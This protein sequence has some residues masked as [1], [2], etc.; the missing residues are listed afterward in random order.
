MTTKEKL[1]AIRDL[2]IK[3]DRSNYD[4]HCW[5]KCALLE[6]RQLKIEHPFDL[7]EDDVMNAGDTTRWHYIFGFKNLVGTNSLV[8]AG[9]KLNLPTDRTDTALDAAYRIDQLLDKYY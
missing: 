1:I 4:Q 3:N 8:E 2:L 5:A 7:G 9:E 6:K